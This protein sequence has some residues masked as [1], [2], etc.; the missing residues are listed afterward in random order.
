MKTL[1]K[2]KPAVLISDIFRKCGQYYSI[3]FVLDEVSFDRN[4]PLKKSNG[5]FLNKNTLK[6][7]IFQGI[8]FN[9][10]ISF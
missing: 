6:T 9:Y 4:G 7:S 2:N 5:L 8:Q 10:I 1:K 3:P